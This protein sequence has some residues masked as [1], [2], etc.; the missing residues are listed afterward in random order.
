MYPERI[1]GIVPG[2]R[3]GMFGQRSY[4]MIVTNYRLIFAMRTN[5]SIRREHEKSMAGTEDQ[6]LLTKWK[7]SIA[8]AFNYHQRYYQMPPESILREGP[9]NYEIRPDQVN[10]V[11]VYPGSRIEESGKHNSNTLK[12][13]WSGGKSKFSF[14]SVGANQVK[15]MLAPLLGPKVR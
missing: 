10:K 6:G 2:L 7:T 3:T 9:D 4:D 5:E 1:T 12:I 13:K 8:S 15:N 11:Q 14:E